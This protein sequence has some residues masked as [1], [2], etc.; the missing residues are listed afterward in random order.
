VGETHIRSQPP[1]TVVPPPR[2]SAEGTSAGEVPSAEGAHTEDTAAVQQALR[3]KEQ[4][5]QE[6]EKL[7]REKVALEAELQRIKAEFNAQRPAA[8]GNTRE[9]DVGNLCPMGFTRAQVPV[10][11]SNLTLYMCG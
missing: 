8:A 1:R 6:K 9:T 7:G 10:S 4:E 2:G 11:V 3:E 5:R